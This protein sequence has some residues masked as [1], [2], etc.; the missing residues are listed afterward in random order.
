MT[1][2]DDYMTK[3][4]S[5]TEL[6]AR[7]D[8][9]CRRVGAEEKKTADELI[10]GPFY[11]NVKIRTLV[12]N[13]DRIRLTQVEF[14]IMKLFMENHDRALSREEILNQVWGKDYFSDLKIVDV[15]IRRLRMKIEEDPTNPEFITTVWGFGYKWGSSLFG[16]L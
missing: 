11:F 13:G 14:S 9:L 16:V 3:P 6:V 5:P 4:F 2:A 10:T 7:I 1:G 8:A 12:K 15:N